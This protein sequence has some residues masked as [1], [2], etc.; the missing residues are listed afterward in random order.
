MSQFFFCEFK[1]LSQRYFHLFII[2]NKELII[3][4]C[5]CLIAFLNPYPSFANSFPSLSQRQE[6]TK[7]TS[8]PLPHPVCGTTLSANAYSV[9]SS[10]SSLTQQKKTF[11]Y[12]SVVISVRHFISNITCFPCNSF[13]TTHSTNKPSTKEWR[14]EEVLFSISNMYKIHPYS[15][16]RFISSC[17][18]R[19][20]GFW[21]ICSKRRCY[22]F[23]YLK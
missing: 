3:I 14:E 15:T 20:P 9:P 6:E 19:I 21:R 13:E 7:E 1:S 12:Q 18:Q 11:L 16:N 17:Q 23:I 4:K 5:C 2:V 10:V 22:A 8:T